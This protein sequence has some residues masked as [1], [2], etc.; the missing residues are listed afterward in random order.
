V[1]GVELNSWLA[2]FDAFSPLRTAIHRLCPSKKTQIVSFK[3]EN[4]LGGFKTAQRFVI[5]TG[6]ICLVKS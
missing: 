3:E 2:R 4:G 5:N 6:E 1:G